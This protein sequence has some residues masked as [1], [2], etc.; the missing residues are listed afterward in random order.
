LYTQDQRLP[1]A[2]AAFNRALALKPDFARAHNNLALLLME[3]GR[4][5]E[6][7]VLFREVLTLTSEDAEGHYNLGILLERTAR[8]SEAEHCYR[9]ALQLNASHVK[10]LNN[11]GLLLVEAGESAEPERLY[12]TAISLQPDYVDAHFNL[13]VLLTQIHQFADAHLHYQ[14]ALELAPNSCKAHNNLAILYTETGRF[15]EA[16]AAYHRALTLNPEYAEAYTNLAFLLLLLGR[17]KEAWPYYEYRYHA[18]M[19]VS[20][21]PLPALPYPQWQGESLIGKSL[22]I[23]PEQGYGDYIQFV[24]Y[25]PLLKQ[26]GLARL[27]LFCTPPLKALLEMVT[28]VDAVITDINALPHH[29]Y[30]VFPLSLPMHFNTTLDNIPGEFP[31]LFALPS[32]MDKWLTRLPDGKFKV[33]LVWRGSSSHKNDAN[34]SLPGL[35]TLAPLWSVPGIT[36]ISLQKGQDEA[37]LPPVDQPITM[38][39]ADIADFADTA[40]IIAQLDLVICVDTSIAHLAGAMA[41]PCWV[42]LPST[43]TDWRWLREREDSPWY[44]SLRLFRQTTPGDWPVKRI[45]DALLALTDR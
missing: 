38:P 34:R 37:V 14:R 8:K 39:G 19:V 18:N 1:E 27:T 42:L 2:E 23:W 25:A 30:W 33:G 29:D 36:F 28:G 3:Q 32:R 31:Y 45:H 21:T 20:E 15:K 41:K 40:A 13:G 43:R 24:R 35:S 11:L 26:S 16:E 9:R 5:I 44:E 4:M 10:T 22:L 7:E 17:Y 6:A 12:R